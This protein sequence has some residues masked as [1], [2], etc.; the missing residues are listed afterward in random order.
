MVTSCCVKGCNT[1]GT[2]RGIT[3]HRFPATDPD[4][5]RL[6]IL[7]CND[8]VLD[9]IDMDMKNRR[10]CHVH[11]VPEDYDGSS[12]KKKLKSFVVPTR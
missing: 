6:W 2:G 10:I 11:F 5:L 12:T 9:E 8:G 7:F 4:V 1:R 3:Y